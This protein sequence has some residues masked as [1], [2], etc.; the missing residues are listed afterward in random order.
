M[1]IIWSKPFH[2]NSM[3]SVSVLSCRTFFS[4]SPTYTCP[5]T[6]VYTFTLK[7]S[8]TYTPGFITCY[9]YVPYI[10]TCWYTYLT[11]FRR[12]DDKVNGCKGSS[13]IG[14]LNEWK[15]I[16]CPHFFNGFAYT[17]KTHHLITYS[18]IPVD[19]YSK[20]FSLT[21]VKLF[22]IVL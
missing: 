18:N 13:W 10:F 9:A 5:H 11:P 1:N 6:H 7:L 20:L 14:Q 2:C 16:F 3:F 17:T 12:Y 8:L 19:V 21:C 22:Q 4:Q 15:H